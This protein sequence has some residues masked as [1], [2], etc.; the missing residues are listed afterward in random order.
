MHAVL[1]PVQGERGLGFLGTFGDVVCWEVKA[2][3][4]EMLHGCSG[5]S[6]DF[7]STASDWMLLQLKVINFKMSIM[8]QELMEKEEPQLEVT[9][10]SS[11]SPQFD[12]KL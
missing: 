10:S 1:W 7:V 8:P 6:E 2:R 4:L 12:C 9:F 5:F 3:V 11:K